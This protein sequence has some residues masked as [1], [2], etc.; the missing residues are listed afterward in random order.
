M[1]FHQFMHIVELEIEVRH[2]PW[3]HSCAEALLCVPPMDPAR[4][5]PVIVCRLVIVEWQRKLTQA[6]FVVSTYRP[7]VVRMTTPPHWWLNLICSMAG[8]E[9]L[10]GLFCRMSGVEGIAE[11]VV[12]AF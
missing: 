6:T 1:H 7:S 11:E 9:L 3:V 12:I 8:P 2:L 5:Q 4:F 10:C